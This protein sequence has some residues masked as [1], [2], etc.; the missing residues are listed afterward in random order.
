MNVICFPRMCV[1]GRLFRFGSV[2]NAGH[3]VGQSLAVVVELK[4]LFDV[5]LGDKGVGVEH[6]IGD[7]RA[8]ELVDELAQ[9]PLDE[10][11]GRVA[12]GAEELPFIDALED[13]L[14][15]VD[16]MNK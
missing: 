4:H 15:V 8:V 12:A 14:V 9:A 7:F 1:R 3:V 2:D 11:G 13:D 16:Y 6:Y 5:F 10:S